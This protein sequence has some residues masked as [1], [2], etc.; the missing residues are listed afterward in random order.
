MP[1]PVLIRGGPTL[2]WVGPD[3]A[4]L[5]RETL[6]DDPVVAARLVADAYRTVPAERRRRWMTRGAG[7]VV[8]T[9]PALRE[10]AEE[11]GQRLAPVPPGAAR[12]ARAHLPTRSIAEERAFLLP[13]ARRMA[14][15]ALSGPG[16]LV[17]AL[18]RE[19]ARLERALGREEGAA[20]QWVAPEEGPLADQAEAQRRFQGEFARHHEA[21]ERRLEEAARDH[22][23][24]LTRLVG[25]KVA[26]R[27]V[28]SAGSR[29]ALARMSASRL[30]LLGARRRPGKDRGPRFGVIYRAPGLDELP[31]SRQGR[32][33]RSLAALAVIAAR[34]DHLTHRDLGEALLLRRDRR[35]GELRRG[36]R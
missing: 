19:E 31:P 22:L 25:A 20:A 16:E 3:G 27:L 29:A 4:L 32:Y 34:A 26:G 8:P 36:A 11:A 30:Q 21:V 24:N 12:A 6:D 13:L 17:V 10:R 15:F 28:A 5:A 35:L 18:A 2:F 23:P 1:G 14:A 7:S 9:E 33:A